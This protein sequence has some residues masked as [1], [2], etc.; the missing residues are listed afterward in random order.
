MNS[1]PGASAEGLTA[2]SPATGVRG[3]GGGATTSL[4]PYGGFVAK[5]R[6]IPW[7]MAAGVVVCLVD[8]LG[9]L[10]DGGVAFLLGLVQVSVVASF[11]SVGLF[12]WHRRPENPMGA[13]MSGVGFAFFLTNL[14]V[15]HSSLTFTIANVTQSLYQAV[16]AHLAL[17]FPTGR[18]RS[19]AER[20][21][22]VGTY[23]WVLGNTIV[24]QLFWAPA[25]YGCRRCPANLLLVSGN[26]GLNDAINWVSAPIGI[27]VALAVLAMIV[28]HWLEIG[29][30]SRRAFG[31]ISW[32]AAP[33][34]ALIIAQNVAQAVDASNRVFLV[35]FGYGPAVLLLL[36]GAFLVSILRSRLDRS[37]VG[38]LVVELE[39]G[40]PP[41]GLTGALARALG[42][43][44]AK[45]AFRLP[46][47]DSFVDPDGVSIDAG[48]TAGRGRA[49]TY[50]DDE[51][52]VA[53]LH[54]AALVDEPELVAAVGAA[55]RLALQNERLRAEIRAQLEEVRASRQRIVEASDAERRRVERNLHD[56]AQQRL[57]TLGLSLRLLLDRVGPDADPALRAELDATAAEAAR[58]VEELRELGRGIHP[59]VL[60]EAGLAAALD[61]LAE[62]SPL[63]VRVLE[64][65]RERF[66]SAVEATAYFVVSEALANCQKHA[67]ASSV[68]VAVH[69]A[70]GR[71]VVSVVDDGVGGADAQAGSGLRG[72]VDRVAALGGHLAVES[73]PGGGTSIRAEIPCG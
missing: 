15:L 46:G 72:L 66:P 70:D 11:V 23:V 28:R 55:A 39:R 54:D 47:S 69:R 60:T 67:G 32:M 6:L 21:V 52:T 18:S 5:R 40:L 9:F 12:A 36:P 62:R 49:V 34:V 57:L 56:G 53:L 25:Q 29:P 31:P 38:D 44:S 19:R 35:L 50:L 43:P 7:L 73:P 4:V 27:L 45:L 48:P 37:V 51:R 2:D 17:T 61:S 16:L 24:G 68:E 26:R 22:I 42:D 10:L 14:G 65:P 64:S 20:V 58:A 1:R 71:L 13:I 63:S 41:G 33:A 8:A 59:A 3:E 30:R